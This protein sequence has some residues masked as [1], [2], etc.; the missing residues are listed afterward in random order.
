LRLQ[1]KATNP[2]L[3]HSFEQHRIETESQVERLVRVF[4]SVGARPGRGA[5]DAVSGVIEE[6]ERLLKR[7]VDPGTCVMHG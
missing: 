3:Q 4:R 5:T 6:A 1:A 2:E 7:Q